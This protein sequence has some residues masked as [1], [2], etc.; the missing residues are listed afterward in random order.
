[1]TNKNLPKKIIHLGKRY[2]F[3]RPLK[4]KSLFRLGNKSDGGYVM[5]K[6]TLANA[7]HLLSFG[8]GDNW[9]FEKDC[10]KLNKKLKIYMYDHTID[11]KIFFRLFFKNL[12]RFITFRGSFANISETFKVLK[13][14]LELKNFSKKK[15]IIYYPFK[16]TNKSKNR[17]EKSIND[18]IKNLNNIII[19]C[20]IEGDEYNLF[21]S[22]N[23]NLKK[24]DLMVIEFHWVEKNFINFRKLIKKFQK[25]HSIIHFHVNN[26]SKYIKTKLPDFVEI[27]FLIKEKTNNKHTYESS[28]PNDNL[29][30]PNNLGLPDYKIYFNKKRR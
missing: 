28:L 30:F 1:M 19:K 18:E 16:I 14:Y 15:N 24:I 20:D 9:S 25:T 6:K 10:L 17:Y 11:I 3:L 13:N 7:H 22:I 2:N 12:R 29:D 8:V 4:Q 23:N 27:T 5:E 26:N 21:K